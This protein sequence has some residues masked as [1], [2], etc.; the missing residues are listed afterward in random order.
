MHKS[1][2]F[3][4]FYVELLAGFE[5]ATSSLPRT[6]STPKRESALKDKNG[7]KYTASCAF[8]A[9]FLL[10]NYNSIKNG[11]NSFSSLLLPF[12]TILIVSGNLKVFLRAS[13]D[14]IAPRFRKTID[15]FFALNLPNIKVTISRYYLKSNSLTK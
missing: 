11:S 15:L 1:L 3:V 6:C 8:S 4:H 14:Q 9:V 13:A 2:R 7:G 5:P 10:F 12:T